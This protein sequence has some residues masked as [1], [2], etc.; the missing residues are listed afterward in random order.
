V[1]LDAIRKSFRQ[2]RHS[3]EATAEDYGAWI[4]QVHH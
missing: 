2:S 3:P 1:R 4:E